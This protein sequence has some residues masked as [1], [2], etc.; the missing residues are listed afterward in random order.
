MTEVATRAAIE[1]VWRLES[2]PLLGGLMRIVRDVDLAVD[3]AQE[4]L[5][6]ALEHWRTEGIPK[7]PGAWRMATAKTGP[8][9]AGPQA[10]KSSKATPSLRRCR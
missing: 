9:D 1:V 3:L 5:V 7:N 2:A 6:S 8:E 10:G 4:A